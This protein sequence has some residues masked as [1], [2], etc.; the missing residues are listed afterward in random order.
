MP[1]YC[2]HLNVKS[3]TGESSVQHTSIVPENVEELAAEYKRLWP[4]M[5]SLHAN[6]A[7]LASK[8]AIKTCAKRLGMLS[9]Q[10]GR[11]SIVFDHELEAEIFQDYLIYMYRPRGFSLVQQMH[12]RKRYQSGSD[13]Q[14]LLEG[15]VQARFS[16]FWIKEVVPAG[17]FVALDVIRG[18]YFFIL[19]Q[20]VARQNVEGMF[21]AF[22]IFPFRGAWMHTGTNMTFGTIEAGAGLQPVGR[23]LNEQ[24][25]RELNEENIRRW[26]ILLRE[27]E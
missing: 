27:M 20:A 23:I 9:R 15:M 17:G 14:M 19:D 5:P 6:I 22:R 13:E 7:R 25:E 21:S 3:Q 18:E 12:N 11:Q 4:L 24:E 2:D 8:D 26:R 10:G 16:A 1:D